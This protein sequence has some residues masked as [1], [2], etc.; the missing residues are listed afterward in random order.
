MTIDIKAQHTKAAITMH[1]EMACD[2]VGE[3]ADLLAV[4]RHASAARAAYYVG[5]HAASAY[6]LLRA[7]EE[8]GAH[9]KV[10]AQFGLLV[11]DDPAIDLDVKRFL[12]KGLEYKNTS[13]YNTKF[14]RDE[15]TR[16]I[17]EDLL[18]TAQK[19][20]ALAEQH[21]IARSTPQKNPAPKI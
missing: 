5:L 19:I 7:G 15:I 13:D 18:T 21:I 4:G 3:V 17:A 1:M 8:A 20:V 2:F 12:N 16:V 11:K 9:D 10:R 14:K 6:I